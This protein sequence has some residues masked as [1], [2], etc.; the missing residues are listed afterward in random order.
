M[1]GFSAL[2]NPDSYRQGGN[3][4]S[5]SRFTN[6][7]LCR[8]N[9][10]LPSSA[11]TEKP[12]SSP[13]SLKQTV[14]EI[15]FEAETT[16]GK[17]FD[18][19]LLWMIGLSVLAVMLETVAPVQARFGK[20]L[21]QAEWAFTI[22]FS[23]E[24]AL[25]LW[26]SRR[27]V[28]YA[29]SFF[30]VIDLISCLPQYLALLLGAGQGF[31]VVR[32]LRLLR[33]FRILKMA[34]HIRGARVIMRGLVAARPKITVFFAAVLM[35][36]TIAGT[37]LFF[38]EGQTAGSDFTSIPISIYYA[39]VSITTVGFGDI[40]V[41]TDLGR[42]ITSLMILTGFAIIAVPTGIVAADISRAEEAEDETTYACPGCGAH[43]HSA[44]ANY[45][46][47]CGTELNQ[48]S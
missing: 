27:P 23:L 48:R 26:V 5:I 6:P 41:Q 24:Y 28:R 36:A 4:G 21:H 10:Y 30:G 35:L 43:G 7:P 42:F 11:V 40:T 37:L 47:L 39:I 16:A 17:A 3:R 38:I 22:L 1:A 8:T 15:I 9:S 2:E 13:R 32:I 25:R 44:D 19:A 46:R 34:H 33:M 18:I 14:W 31:A 12:T 20:E 45:C 29:T